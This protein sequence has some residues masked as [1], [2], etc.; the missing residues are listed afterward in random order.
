V[1][2]VGGRRRA[3]VVLPS[4]EPVGVLIPDV[5]D[6]LGEPAG[7]VPRPR[8]LVTSSGLALPT[9]QS[10]AAAEVPDGAV[11]RV[12][13]VEDSPP[14]PVIHD[15]TEETA[16]A[17]DRLS[18]RWSPTARRWSATA[19]AVV[20]FFVAGLLIRAIE[21]GG[22][23]VLLLAVAAALGCLLG[24]ALAQVREPIGTVVL[25]GS[26]VLAVQA[27]WFGGQSS[28]WP[29]D[30][31][32]LLLAAVAGVL[33]ALLGATTPLGRGGWLG[34]GFG[35]LLAALWWV[36]MLIH[37]PTARL[38]AVMAAVAAVL[39]GFLPRLAL[40]MAGLTRLDD[41]RTGG[42]DVSR[43]DVYDALAASHRG[44]ALATVALAASSAVSG[45]A[46]A[47]HPDRWTLSLSALLAVVLLSRAR[48]YPLVGEVF[49]LT[50]AAGVALAGLFVAWLRATGTPEVGQLAV[51]ALGALA[52]VLVLAVDPP[53]HVRARLRR[54]ADRVE[55]AAVLAI[56]PVVVGEFGTYGRLLHIF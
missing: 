48:L 2:L 21:P 13:T 5:L 22:S 11:L 49:A 8:Q 55:S 27:A 23:G 36:G 30:E 15:V 12:V 34:G 16:E 54:L 1:T 43:R 9:G 25:L 10:L 33:V 51:T 14:A 26:G 56:V 35:V 46:L 7:R 40:V 52:C 4:D 39:L 18:F 53:D 28:R 19:G 3:D 50:G 38:S 17:A 6:L 47:D 24:A 41:A 29:A 37:L 32:W 44:L 20:L 45:W 31:R 42:G